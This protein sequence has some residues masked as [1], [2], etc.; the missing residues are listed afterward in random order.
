[1]SD[2]LDDKIDELDRIFFKWEVDAVRDFKEE[3]QIDFMESLEVQDYDE[4]DDDFED[5]NNNSDFSDATSGYNSI[6]KTSSIKRNS[7]MR[8]KLM[9]KASTAL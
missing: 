4:S 6:G 1:M 8:P 9:K 7:R 3:A 2:Q 5:A